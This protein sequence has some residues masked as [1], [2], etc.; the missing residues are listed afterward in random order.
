MRK[1]GAA[2]LAPPLLLLPDVEDLKEAFLRCNAA[3]NSSTR[4]TTSVAFE[5]SFCKV[6]MSSL[7]RK[8]VASSSSKRSWKLS[9]EFLLDMLTQR[10]EH[11]C[12]MS[13]SVASGRTKPNNDD[14]VSKRARRRPH[15]SAP[16]VP[17]QRLQNR[18]RQAPERVQGNCRQK[19]AGLR[20]SSSK[21]PAGQLHVTVP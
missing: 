7:S 9:R 11:N 3:L 2:C 16:Q 10:K 12:T 14:K 17:A 1:R 13:C 20:G 21:Q 5:L 6:A 18:V 4:P 8:E 15:Q 19:R